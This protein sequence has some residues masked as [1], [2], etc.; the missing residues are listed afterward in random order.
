MVNNNVLSLKYIYDN[1][2]TWF[3]QKHNIDTFYP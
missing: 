2:E 3:E 1:K